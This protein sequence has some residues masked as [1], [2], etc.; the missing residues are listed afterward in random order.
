MKKK[1]IL[2]LVSLCLLATGNG[3]KCYSDQ[4]DKIVKCD[5][6]LGYRTCFIRYGERGDVTGRGCSTKDKVYYKE[7]ETNSYGAGTEKFCYCNFYLC[8]GALR[9]SVLSSTN[10]A[11]P[12][13]CILLFIRWYQP[14]L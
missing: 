8:N 2:F 7:C 3:L 12:F 14:D 6:N 9:S 4:L 5:E 13:L 10:L 1:K 11:L